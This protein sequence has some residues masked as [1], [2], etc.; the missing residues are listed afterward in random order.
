[1][2][3][4]QDVAKE[5]TALVRAGK[6]EEAMAR[7]YADDIVSIEAA[8]P[9]PVATGIAAV[10][11]KGE[12]FDANFTVNGVE[13]EGPFVNG[14]EFAILMRV[15]VTPK[16][17]SPRHTMEEVGVYSVRDGKIAKERFFYGG[18]MGEG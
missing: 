3:V 11:R 7:F 1:M 8:G 14:E 9:E 13:V 15:D 2:A 12:W 4:V 6:F 10:Q 16:D 5:L 17:G 18:A